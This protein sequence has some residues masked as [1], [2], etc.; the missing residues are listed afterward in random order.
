MH[1]WELKNLN[2]DE[3]GE[4]IKAIDSLGKNKLRHMVLEMWAELE[5]LTLEEKK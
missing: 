3:M 1:T 5:R 4:L 2:K